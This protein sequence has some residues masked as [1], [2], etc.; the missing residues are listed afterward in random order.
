[1][2]VAVLAEV[3]W[4]HFSGSDERATTRLC[5][6]WSNAEFAGLCRGVEAF[7]EHVETL[8]RWQKCQDAS[9][10]AR[11]GGRRLLPINPMPPSSPWH[12]SMC[13]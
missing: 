12:F 10:P 11:S 3:R 6:L 2:L 7:R 5:R 9:L 4:S 13:E 8:K 1:M